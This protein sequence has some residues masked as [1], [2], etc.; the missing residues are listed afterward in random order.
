MTTYLVFVNNY[1]RFML[2][3]YV[4]FSVFILVIVLSVCKIIYTALSNVSFHMFILV[5]YLISMCND[6]N[7]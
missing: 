2:C 4:T 5:E 3:K 7:A 6:N 1:Y